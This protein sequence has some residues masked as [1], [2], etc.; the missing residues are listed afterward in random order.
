MLRLLIG[1]SPSKIFHLKEFAEELNNL[2]VNCKLVVD[3]DICKGFPSRNIADW[4][5]TKKKI[6]K[7]ILEF[8]P[9]IILVD[10]QRHFAKISS[11]YKI[12]LIIHLRGNI[13]KEIEWAKETTYKSFLKKIALGVWISIAKE[14]F[15]KSFLIIPICKHLEKIVKNNYPNK[16]T[17]VMYQGISSERWYPSK[18]M[19]LQHP[20]V[21]LLQGAVIWGKAQEMFVLEKVLKSMPNVM[22]YWVGDGPYRKKILDVLDKYN[23]FKWLGALEYPEKVRQYLTEIDVYALISG[24]DMSPLTLQESQLMKKPVVATNVGG[25]PELMKDKE[26]GFLV[27]KGNAEELIKKLTILIEDKEK[28]KNMG[29]AGRKFVEDNFSW[30]KIAKDFINNLEEVGIK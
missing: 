14:T 16:K 10:R 5:Q 6:Q 13:W 25:I 2:G 22:F 11:E 19:K 21:G 8:K 29:N 3:T 20:C 23:N 15:D 17:A 1:G 18:G 28:R 7:L 26:T 4:F 30:D 9:D 24:I 27:E 12:P